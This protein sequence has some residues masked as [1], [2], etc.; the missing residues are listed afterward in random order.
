MI[1]LLWAI[2]SCGSTEL[3]GRYDLPES[4]GVASAPYPRLVDVPAAPPPGQTS[5]SV[6]NPAEGQA[7]IDGLAPVTA[8]QA[9]R[10]DALSAPVLT[11]EERRRLGR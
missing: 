10:A 2:S 9:R 6:P 7:V 3:F 4:P 5:A 1:P 8:A 11:E